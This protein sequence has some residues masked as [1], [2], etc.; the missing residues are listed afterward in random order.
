MKRNDYI[1]LVQRAQ[2]GDRSAFAEL[3]RGYQDLAAGTAFGWLGDAEA[4]RDV[5]QE[6]FLDAH[7]HLEQLREPAAFPGW[8]RRIVL[9]HC[10]RV[11]RRRKVATT[12]LQGVPEPAA[13]DANPDGYAEAGERAEWLRFAVESLPV[14]ERQLVALH[15]FA[16]ATNP[17]LAEFLELPLS[18]IKKR[19]RS[20]RGRLRSEGER[21]MQNTIDKLRPSTGGDLTQ[22]VCFFIALRAGDRAEVARLLAESPELV[23]ARQ[24]WGPDLVLEGVLPFANKA[25][26][27]ITAVEQDDLGMLE[28]LLDAGADV[29]GACGCGTGE[30]PVWAATLFDRASHARTLLEHGADPNIASTVGNY[31]LHVAAMRGH[32]ALVE[33]LLRHG[34]DPTLE[35]AGPQYPS[36]WSSADGAGADTRG[37]TPAQWARA[38][39]NAELAD[40]LEA[41]ADG[42]ARA[43]VA[44][45]KRQGLELVNG[46]FHTGIKALDLFVPIRR[47]GL[48]RIPFKAGVGMVVLLAELCA[49]FSATRGGV[50]LW[51][52]FSQPPFDLSDWE[53][54]MAET[55]LKDAVRGSLASFSESPEMRRKAFQRGIGMAERL[56]DEGKDVLAVVLTTEGFENDVE[57]SLL[58]LAGRETSAPGSITSLIVTSFPAKEG[59]VWA[60]LAAPFSA[61]ITFDPARARSYLFP[62]LDPSLSLSADLVTETVGERHV[63]LAAEAKALLGAYR[64]RDPDYDRLDAEN[65]T[66]EEVRA[67]RLLRYL[68]QPFLVAEPFIGRRGEWVGREDLLDAVESLMTSP[69]G[70]DAGH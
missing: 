32:A 16:E 59:D 68:C 2:R 20:A 51:T 9:K 31:P 28:L 70:S 14:P 65:A 29:D 18:T 61:Q 46:V 47:G 3:V 30:S 17:E 33:L 40:R 57:A 45:G 58:R 37:R 53:A 5:T 38:N 22:E 19:L 21:L 69:G 56:R 25:T 24:D 66:A 55:G 44:A 23:N 41:A 39:G 42:R 62:A 1:S 67:H 52:G 7:L 8:L 26:A 11:T 48:I 12:T 64:E 15:Y 10:D 50:A 49:R 35:D 34:A 60:E 6:A 4:A 13:A 27:L 43:D 36:P 54:E 63:R